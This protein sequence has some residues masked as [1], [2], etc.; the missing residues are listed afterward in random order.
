MM[1][2]EWPDIR[3]IPVH[4]SGVV[5][6]LGAGVSAT[7]TDVVAFT[8]DDAAPRREWLATLSHHL[9]D[10]S[11]GAVGGRD[12]VDLPSQTGPL[13]SRVGRL[14]RWGRIAGNHHLGRGPA[15]DVAVLKGVNMAFRRAALSLPSGL[16]GSGAQVD[17]ELAC[18]L[19][20]AASGWRLVYDPCAVVDHTVG[21]RFDANQRDRP[22]S[23]AVSDAAYNR[24]AILLSLRPMLGLRRA[25]FGLVV[26]ERSTPGLLRAAVAV[27]RGESDVLRRL[28]PS[29]SGQAAALA[30][31]GR[32][33]RV[34]MKSASDHE[35][36][37]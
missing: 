13:T 19:A 26:G 16:R 30:D 14:G 27:A 18:C 24:L 2:G 4:Q 22:D 15:Q 21:P 17:F 35:L 28:A 20:A 7:Q 33:R 3:A 10:P 23:T 37:T 11:V 29:V 9:E 1:L 6:A 32:G 25:A 12:V 8:D 5:S 34:R 31:F 36:G